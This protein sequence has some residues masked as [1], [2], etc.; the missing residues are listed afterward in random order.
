MVR[1]I[2]II[3]V[4][5]LST[6]TLGC[7]QKESKP[8]VVPSEYQHAKDMLD[9]LHKEGLGIQEINNSKYT[10][11]FN[12]NPNYS[13]FI[14]TDMGI[15]ELVHLERKNGKE[16]DIQEAADNGEYKY[17]IS[18]NGV[19][20]LLILGSENYFNKSDEYI[21]IARNKNLNDKIKQALKAL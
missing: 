6:L 17:V 5:I 21:T 1:K 13:M 7:S 14:K 15:F 19:D 3:L 9:H 10:A 8:L 11:L 20:Q 2:C 4:F 16:I 18:E 12:T